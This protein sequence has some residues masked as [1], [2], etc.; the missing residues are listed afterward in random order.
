[1]IGAHEIV[2]DPLQLDRE[3]LQRE[4]DEAEEMY[5]MTEE[6]KCRVKDEVGRMVNEALEDLQNMWAK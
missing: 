1:M 4:L 5:G 3:H 6:E 2:F